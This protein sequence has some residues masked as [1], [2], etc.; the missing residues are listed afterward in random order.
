MNIETLTYLEKQVAEAKE[1]QNRIAMIK[2]D[3]ETLETT[4]VKTMYL[5]LGNA[6]RINLTYLL[7]VLLE[8]I[9]EI[10]AGTLE[11]ELTKAEAE[12]EKL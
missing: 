12:F 7:E 2:E 8:P 5:G 6:R 11:S 3:I 1:V 9:M 10:I 4:A